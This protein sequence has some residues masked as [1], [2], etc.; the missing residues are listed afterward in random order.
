MI[1]SRSRLLLALLAGAAPGPF[2][3]ADAFTQS[4]GPVG[5]L[6]EEGIRRGVYPGAVVVVGRADTVLYARGFGRLTFDSR[7]RRPSAD[8]TLWDLASVT[9]VVATASAALVLVDRGALDLDA[10]VARYLPR[11]TG[12][13][14]ERVTVRMFLDHTS[15][16]RS[17]RPIYRLTRTRQAAVDL[18]LQEPLERPPGSAVVYSD[19]NAMLLGLVVEAA[20]G[21]PLDRFAAKAVFSPLGMTRTGFPALLPRGLPAAPSRMEGGRPAPRRVQDDNARRL[22]GV[23]GHAGVFATGLDLARFAQTWLREGR[24]AD[25][26]QWVSA[27]LLRGFLVRGADSTAR[28]LGWDVPDRSG[29]GPSNFGILTSERTVGHTGWTGT[30]LWLD[31]ARDL[32]LVFLTNRSLAPRARR[33]LELIREIRAAVSDATLR[34]IVAADCAAARIFAC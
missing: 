5:V 1:S 2:A 8:S 30:V 12:G 21:E 6:V 4:F 25:G 17:Y 32:F 11:F 33:S 31:P 34:A 29:E 19:L 26:R 27:E 10:P 14:R 16:L 23:A 3:G 22:G 28:A 9:K 7:A 18:L 24:L 20:A 13:G 15:G